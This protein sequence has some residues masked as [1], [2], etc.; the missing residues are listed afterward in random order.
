M[1][2]SATQPTPSPFNFPKKP[3][4]FGD[5]SSK[6]MSPKVSAIENP[7]LRNPPMG[8]SSSGINSAFGSGNSSIRVLNITNSYTT[9]QSLVSTATRSPLAP[10]LGEGMVNFTSAS[11]LSQQSTKPKIPTAASIPPPNMSLSRLMEGVVGPMQTVSGI[12]M[13]H[14]NCCFALRIVFPRVCTIVFLKTFIYLDCMIPG[15]IP[16]KQEL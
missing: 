13:G 2:F 11:S 7:Y 12:W 9:P 4:I 3:D 6:P 8:G 1:A 16:P 10:L 14:C 15:R 5:A